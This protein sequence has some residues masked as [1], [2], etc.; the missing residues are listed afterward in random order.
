MDQS[1]S[2]TSCALAVNQ[3]SWIAKEAIQ[4]IIIVIIMKTLVSYAKVQLVALSI[5]I[6]EPQKVVTVLRNYPDV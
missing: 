3:T 1:G 4:L 2:T 6:G 5:N